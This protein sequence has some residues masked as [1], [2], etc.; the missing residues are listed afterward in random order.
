MKSRMVR[1]LWTLCALTG[2]VIGAWMSSGCSAFSSACAKAL[3]VL[4]AA[5]A[6]MADAQ[7]SLDQAEQVVEAMP[8]GK[9]RDAAFVALADAR[10]ALRVAASQAALAS[11]A[12]SQPDLP[13]LF[14]AFA[15]AWDALKPFLALLGGTGASSVADPEAYRIGLGQ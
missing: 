4:T 2:L 7:V 11:T 1:L 14:K 13:T 6:Y 3:P 8:E 15:I 9:V 12:C 10:A 5:E